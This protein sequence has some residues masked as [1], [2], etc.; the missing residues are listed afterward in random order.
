MREDKEFIGSEAL[1][2]IRERVAAGE[3]DPNARRLRCLVLD[4]P[5][6]VTLGNEPVRVGDEVVGRVT[7]GG[8]G[9][10]V[11]RSI[12]YAYLPAACEPGT[13]ARERLLSGSIPIA[14]SF[15]ASF[16]TTSPPKVTPSPPAPFPKVCRSVVAPW[17]HFPPPSRG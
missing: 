2:A 17:V 7:S 14:S 4:D 6:S 10:T 16:A 12:A 5:L 1:R 13:L 11:E 8:Y 9:Y 15:T 3:G